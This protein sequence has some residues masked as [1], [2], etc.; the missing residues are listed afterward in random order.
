LLSFGLLRD[1]G[2][3]V[4]LAQWRATGGKLRL[5][6]QQITEIT[7]QL[8]RRHAA[9]TFNETL[10]LDHDHVHCLASTDRM[11]TW[12]CFAVHAHVAKKLEA[13]SLSPA[14]FVLL[15]AELRQV[16]KHI[17]HCHL[18][19]SSVSWRKHVLAAQI[20][21]RSQA[22]RLK[23]G[24]ESR[25]AVQAASGKNSRYFHTLGYENI[26]LQKSDFFHTQKVLFHTL[27]NYF[28]PS[29]K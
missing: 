5:T 22:L 13:N 21:T 2:P 12:P 9:V 8:K 26:F 25:Q 28:I 23:A 10:P 15:L 27:K 24:S 11:M 7:K 4:G 16:E 29:K 14:A 1:D 19:R 17:A 20:A 3:L 18:K 6:I